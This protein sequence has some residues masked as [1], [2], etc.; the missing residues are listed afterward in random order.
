MLSLI[1]SMNEIVW[2]SQ[3]RFIVFLFLITLKHL[4]SSQCP[5]LSS[6]KHG[7]LFYH[8]FPY[9]DFIPLTHCFLCS[10]PKQGRSE[11]HLD[12]IQAT[13]KTLN[14]WSIPQESLVITRPSTKHFGFI[15]KEQRF[16]SWKEC[17]I[18]V[19]K[20]VD[21]SCISQKAKE[22]TQISRV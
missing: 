11:W 17:K 16:K 7:F 22:I 15:N 21:T 18:Q 5:L 20:G 9:C 8:G 12:I 13:G 10:K 14:L 1:T 2:W 19:E 6:S 3:S 4:L